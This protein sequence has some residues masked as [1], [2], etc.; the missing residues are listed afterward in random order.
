ME[1]DHSL[2]RSQEQESVRNANHL[3]DSGQLN[4]SVSISHSWG[5]GPARG[6]RVVSFDRL[7]LW[8]QSLETP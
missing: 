6:G 7:C 5:E 8:K 4:C 3:L 1:S 2:V